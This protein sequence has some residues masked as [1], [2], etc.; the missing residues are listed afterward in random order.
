MKY[1]V[2]GGAGFIG[3]H[4]VDRLVPMAAVTVYDNLSSGKKEFIEHHSGRDGFEFIQAD[5]LDF[6]TL[7]RA[8]KPCNVVF[9]MAAN[10]E[11]R[12]D[13]EHTDLDLKQG[14][15]GTCSQASPYVSKKAASYRPLP[16]LKGSTPCGR[17]TT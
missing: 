4:L 1:F 8:M 3:S 10:P 5:I 12:V 9:H 15:I 11:A 13:I 2:I 7:K 17:L 14:T 16:T 6:D